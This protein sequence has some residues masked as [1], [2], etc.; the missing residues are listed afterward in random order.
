MTV[1]PLVPQL[2]LKQR[3][4]AESP[5]WAKW[6]GGAAGVVG[7]GATA[8]ATLTTIPK[9]WAI[10]AGLIALIMGA[11]EKLS[12]DYCKLDKGGIVAVVTTVPDVIKQVNVIGEDV[13]KAAGV[14]QKEEKNPIG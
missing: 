8:I 5:V 12:V 3:F 11:I 14:V 7:T 4:L 2:T 9:T 10:V 1:V 6:L 13:G